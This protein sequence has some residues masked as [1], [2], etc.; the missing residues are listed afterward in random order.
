MSAAPQPRTVTDARELLDLAELTDIVF[1]ETYARRT[2]DGEDNP[3]AIQIA[4]RREE[5][6]LEIRCRA[7]VAGAGGEY[8]TDASA[9]FT[10]H[11]PIEA[12]DTVVAEFVERVGVMSVYP[13][14][15]ESITQS[16]AKLGLDRPILKLLRPGDVHVTPDIQ[17][18]RVAG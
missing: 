17:D 3:L 13:Y 1:Y 10:L 9:V 16:A 4:L 11:E 12:P 7:T 15:R 18:P 6:V 2:S 8:L 5:L 14:L